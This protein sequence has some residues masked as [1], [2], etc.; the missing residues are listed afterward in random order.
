MIERLNPPLFQVIDVIFT[1]RR[2]P[3]V[4]FVAADVSSLIYS[5]RFGTH[6]FEML[7]FPISY[8]LLLVTWVC[9]LL[10]ECPHD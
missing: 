4:I 2:R 1:E 10:S 7:P 8:V 9:C 6:D 5:I 3:A